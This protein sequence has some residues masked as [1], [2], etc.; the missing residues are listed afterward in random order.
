ML[1]YIMYFVFSHFYF[2][3]YIFMLKFFPHSTFDNDDMKSSK[4][5]VTFLSL[6]FLLKQIL[7]RRWENRTKKGHILLRKWGSL[8]RTL[9]LTI[10]LNVLLKRRFSYKMHHFLLIKKIL[11]PLPTERY[12]LNEIN[13]AFFNFFMEW[14]GRQD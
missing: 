8:T 9:S 3:I 11:S 7:L 6:I 12:I 4:R 14:Q 2:C 1:Y 13:N 5:Q 10:S